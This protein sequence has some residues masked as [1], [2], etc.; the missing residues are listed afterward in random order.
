MKIIG[1]DGKTLGNAPQVSVEGDGALGHEVAIERTHR[2][3]FARRASYSARTT[4]AMSS[5]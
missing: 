2:E 4:G 1:V 5:Q 3:S